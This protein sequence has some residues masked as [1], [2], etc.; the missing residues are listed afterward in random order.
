MIR[1]HLMNSVSPVFFLSRKSFSS[2]FHTP[3]FIL[4]FGYAI[5]D[6]MKR[7]L[8]ASV[9]SIIL[10]S[11]V[12]FGS[13]RAYA[14]VVVSQPDI[15]ATSE[16]RHTD[17]RQ[18]LSSEPSQFQGTF[19]RARFKANTINSTNMEFHLYESL[20]CETRIHGGNDKI[21]VFTPA[22]N[23]ESF[24]EYIFDFPA[25]TTSP[26]KCYWLRFPANYDGVKLLGSTDDTSYPYGDLY[27][28]FTIISWEQDPIIKD[29]YFSLEFISQNQPPTLSYSPEPGYIDDGINPDEGDTETSFAFKI[30]YTDTDNNPPADIRTVVYDGNISNEPAVEVS[31]DAM[32][33]DSF[34]NA[35]LHDG[36]YANGEQYSLTKSF[37]TG[38]YR[39]RLQASDGEIGTILDGIADGK[40]QRFDVKENQPPIASFTFTPQNPK[41]GEAVTFNAASSIDPDADGSITVYIWD[42]GNN[43]AVFTESPIIDHKFLDEGRYAVKLLIIDNNK[44]VGQ[45]EQEIYVNPSPESI[46]LAH[47][48]A[49]LCFLKID[50]ICDQDEI[51]EEIDEWIRDRD[52][53]NGPDN[54]KP[55]DWLTGTKCGGASSSFKQKMCLI[56]AL[57][58]EIADDGSGLTYK[59]YILKVMR[60]ERITNGAFIKGPY[61]YPTKA[62]LKLYTDISLEVLLL[63]GI[64]SDVLK[65]LIALSLASNLGFEA[66]K[67]SY[68]A[69]FGVTSL[70]ATL[71]TLSVNKLFG[72]ID[73]YSYRLA[74]K[75][76]FCIRYDKDEQTA[77]EGS[78]PFECTNNAVSTLAP[79]GLSPDLLQQIRANFDELWRKYKTDLESSN[80]NWNW[81]SSGL[82]QKFKERI[83]NGIENLIITLVKNK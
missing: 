8:G 12:L 73:E 47:I 61:P 55:F 1:I 74:L 42:F 3:Y 44:G 49:A 30:V 43:D 33:L 22:R 62:L 50:W 58:K 36:N 67:A 68:L 20:S 54:D 53:N 34:A 52:G 78:Q 45:N 27:Q 48:G 29:A 81:A 40:E 60:E 37:P 66:T 10:A 70:S 56:K 46:A 75:N 38:I 15:N 79:M 41:A 13:S 35:E 18:L 59:E 39:Y 57:N 2:V 6:L 9:I 19:N 17:W 21:G 65:S 72:Y 77:W 31:S 5:F 4:T 69:N 82:P 83:R 25:F 71:T 76:Y 80:P 64:A 51:A 26:D 63:K 7:L 28:G 32:V 23:G 24:E 16:I 14:T 11:G